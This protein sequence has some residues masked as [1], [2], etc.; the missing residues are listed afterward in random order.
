MVLIGKKERWYASGHCQMCDAD[1][2]VENLIETALKDYFEV[3]SHVAAKDGGESPLY[4][5]PDCNAYTYVIW[6][7]ENGCVSCGCSLGE[8]LRCSA[9]LTPDTVAYDN[10]E[11]CGYCDNLMS[12]DD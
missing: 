2:P 10:N 12:K 9:H 3:E 7:D 8:C 4:R 11:L 5:C 6:E 1:I